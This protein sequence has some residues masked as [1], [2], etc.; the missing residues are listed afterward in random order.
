MKSKPRVRNSKT[1]PSD[2][3]EMLYRGILDNALDCVITMGGDG[4]VLEFNPVAERVFGFNRSEAIGKELA[5]EAVC[6]AIV[7]THGGS[8]RAQ[9]EGSG[10]GATFGVTL[11]VAS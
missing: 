5:L 7:E 10:K 1:V 11:P 4:R 2:K 6:K 3:L 8:I 9:S